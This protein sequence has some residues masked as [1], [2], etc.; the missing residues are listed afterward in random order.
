[1]LAN[2]VTDTIYLAVIKNIDILNTLLLFLFI[3]VFCF[4]A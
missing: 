4:V 3:Y 2:C 1:M